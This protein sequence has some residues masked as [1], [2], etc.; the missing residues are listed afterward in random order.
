MITD[1]LKV[2]VT[3]AEQ[4]NFSQAAKLLNL[5]QP[6]VSLH[7]RN[8]EN[9]LGA[10]LM[11]RTPKLVKL[12]EAGE[13]LFG[14]AQQ[15]LALYEEAKQDIHMLRDEVTGSLS[16]GAS[17]TIGEYILPRVLA[18]YAQQYPLVD[19]QVHISN[20]D[21]ILQDIRAG[22]FHIGLVEG[23][24][25]AK[26]LQVTTFMKDE[27][28]LIASPD[29]PLSSG[30]AVDLSQLQGQIWVMRETGSGTRT[31]SD[32]LIQDGGLSVKRSFVFNSSQGVKEAAACGLG[33][34]LLSRWVV[35][36]ELESGELREVPIRGMQI[37]R[38]LSLL[39]SKDEPA[40][41]AV[42]KFIQAL[43]QNVQS[44]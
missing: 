40:V 10:K 23:Q 44:L 24:V 35:R 28:V 14:K 29:H 15:I 13:I 31:Y 3:V 37:S 42:L 19:V 9:E 5:S 22:R 1:T 16:M 11:H 36:K 41:M 8:L 17:F 7:I 4:R 2:F 6:G 12:T 43:T 34:A 39:Q 30:K 32:R 33:I 18:E 38:D 21:N 20:S 26:D 27:M 25:D